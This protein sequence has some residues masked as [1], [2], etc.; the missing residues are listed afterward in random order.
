MKSFALAT[1][2]FLSLYSMTAQAERLAIKGS[3]ANIRSGPGSSHDVIWQV[4]Q[5]YP[6]EVIKKEGHWIQFRDFE[7]DIGW[8]HD[9]LAGQIKSVIT[10]KP[11]CNI[12]KGPGTQH[13]IVFTVESGIPFRV[14][15]HEG[16]W[17][18]IEHA[19]GDRGW[20]HTSLVW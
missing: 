13:D 11:Q 7:N 8:V 1:F 5:Y 16:D 17:I 4:Q 10:N 3:V 6:F 15:E 9:S 20:I 14:L 18:H 12:R 19:D 2:L